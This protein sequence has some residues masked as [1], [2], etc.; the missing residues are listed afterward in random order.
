[1]IPSLVGRLQT[2]LV[3]MIVIGGLWSAFYALITPVGL[4]DVFAVLAFATVAGF[5]WEFVYHLY[6][7][8]RWDHDFPSGLAWFAGFAELIP[9]LIFAAVLDLSLGF[10]A[11][12]FLIAYSLIWIFMQ[13]PIRVIVPRWRFRAG[14]MW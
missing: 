6:A 13:G 5:C 9:V 7:S 2:R 4:G 12:H 14:R 3:L 10:V 11:V 8:K 1:M